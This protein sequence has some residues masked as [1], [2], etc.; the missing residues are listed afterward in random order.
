MIGN[1]RLK[2]RRGLKQRRARREFLTKFWFYKLFPDT[3]ILF[4]FGKRCKNPKSVAV[5]HK[6]NFSGILCSAITP[7]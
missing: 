2:T 1:F 6:A 7:A 4:S 5:L 3:A